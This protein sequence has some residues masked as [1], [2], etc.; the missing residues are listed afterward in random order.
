VASSRSGIAGNVVS[1]VVDRV[2]G[3]AG[4]AL[5]VRAPW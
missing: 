3:V 2:I 1:V 4:V 5:R